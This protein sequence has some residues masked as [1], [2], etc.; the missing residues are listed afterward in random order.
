MRSV[1]SGYMKRHLK[2]LTYVDGE[3]IG[4]QPIDDPFAT[5]SVVTGWSFTGWLKM[6]FNR[7]RELVV[8]VKIQGDNVA[9]D[10]WFAG[11]DTCEKCQRN[12]IGKTNYTHGDEI[13][14]HDCHYDVPQPPKPVGNYCVEN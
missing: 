2:S 10:R 7:R 14:C 6:L 11:V 13:W 12:N 4:E 3:K 8:R 5:I 1:M 9:V